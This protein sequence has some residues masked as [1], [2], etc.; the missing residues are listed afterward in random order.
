MPTTTYTP[1][2]SQT[3]NT[4]TSTVTFSSIV[5][6]YRDLI[7]IV[8]A[9]CTAIAEL[10]CVV[11]SDFSS[12]YFWVSAGASN[13]IIS[14]S[15]S[16]ATSAMR[17]TERG[18]YSSGQ[19]VQHIIHFLDYSQTDKHKTVLARNNGSATG[20]GMLANRWASTSAITTI[21]LYPNSGSFTAGSTF[22]LYGI[23]G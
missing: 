2:A 8:D 19:Q 4:A 16:G 14:Q 18:S 11:N 20:V 15:S 17:F 3:L 21:Q 23:A 9:G 22:A 5:G 10:N 7:I 6:T 12:N 13:I 1:I